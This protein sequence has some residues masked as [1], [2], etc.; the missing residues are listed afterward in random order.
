MNHPLASKLLNRISELVFM[1][2]SKWA[3]NSEFFLELYLIGFNG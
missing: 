2:G 1:N 3:M